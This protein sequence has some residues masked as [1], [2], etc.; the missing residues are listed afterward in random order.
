MLGENCCFRF[1]D[2]A[3]TALDLSFCTADP[4]LCSPAS[5]RRSFERCGD[6]ADAATAPACPATAGMVNPCMVCAK[7]RIR[8]R[9][10]GDLRLVSHHD[11]MRCWERMLRR[12]ELP[13]HSTAGF[14]PKPRLV[15]ALSLALGI[16]GWDEVVELELDA[17]L[18]PEEI[19][20]RLARQAPAGLEIFDVQR[21][22][23]K[24]TAHVARVT[25]RIKVARDSGAGVVEERVGSL[26]GAS[27]V[28]VE[29]KHPQ[30]RR[31]NIRP[32]IDSV[33]LSPEVL[34]MDLWVT[35]NGTARPDELLAFLGLDHLRIEGAVLERIKLELHDEISPPAN[36]HSHTGNSDQQRPHS[37]GSQEIAVP[38]AGAGNRDP[39]KTEP[40]PM[41]LISGPL[42][43]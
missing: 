10:A 21:I 4:C 26:L 11:L 3:L 30:P 39:V 28:W 12:A 37:E 24:A 42:D 35:P 16:V 34:E 25:Y 2:S 23:P 19:K 36:T 8:F 6:L 41:P 14:N 40:R 31:V 17:D 22:D 13:F 18:P 43:Y 15:F 9:K 20:E 7:V 38:R 27:E 32:Y 29:R 1:G 5:R 33:R